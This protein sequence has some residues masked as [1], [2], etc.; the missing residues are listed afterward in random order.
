MR[1]DKILEIIRPGEEWSLHKSDYEGLIWHSN[2]PKP[3][4]VEIKAAW[5]KVQ[6]ILAKNRADA[7]LKRQVDSLVNEHMHALANEDEASAADIRAKIKEIKG[8][9]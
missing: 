3:T 2:T 9:L 7:I 1:I 5:P 8:K 4:L 6:E